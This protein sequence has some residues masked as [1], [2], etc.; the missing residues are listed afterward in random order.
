[1]QSEQ[2]TSTQIEDALRVLGFERVKRRPGG[3][4]AKCRFHEDKSTHF[5]ISDKGLWMCWSCPARG[6]FRQLHER[7]GVNCADWRSQLD[8]LKVQFSQEREHKRPSRFAKL[9]P[10]FSPYSLPVEVPPVISKRLKWETIQKFHLG[11]CPVGRLRGRCV[12]PIFYKDR[13]IGYHGRALSKDVEPRYYNPED[14]AI[15]DY[16]FNY[17]SV[18]KGGELFVVEGAFNAMSMVEKGFPNTVAVFGIEFKS[19]QIQKIFSLRPS[20]LITCFDRDPSRIDD[21][22]VERGRNGQRATIKLGK[23][24]GDLIKVEV[25]PLPFDKDPNDLSE[26]VLRV[27]YNKRVPFDRLVGGS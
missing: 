20:C 17:D 27:C 26:D 4:N 7:L 19:E 11:S 21:K 22:G 9:P 6:N 24:V 16:V 14:F 23:L 15:K 25:M 8:I 10:E 18:Q 2:Y 1:M 12:I 5:T 3:F 13:C